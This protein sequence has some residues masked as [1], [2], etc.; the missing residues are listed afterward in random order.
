LLTYIIK[1]LLWV[2]PV[3][4]G[5]SIIV[6]IAMN[7]APGDPAQL[8]LGSQATEESLQKLR[9]EM[10]LDRNVF[11]QYGNFIS[12]LLVGDFGRSITFRQDVLPLVLM[13]LH[14]SII[15]GVASLLIAV[16]LGMGLGI[17]SAVKKNTWI[18]KLCMLFALT[19]ISMPIF[20][21]GLLLILFFSQTFGVLPSS[22]MYSSAGGGMFDLLKHII[23]PAFTLSLVPASVIARMTRSS[24]LE[25]IKQDYIR[26]ARAKGNNYW[27]VIVIH[28][29]K[30]A[31]VPVVTVLGLQV[32]YVIGG[33]VVVETIFAWPGVGQLLLEAVLTR[34]F[35]VVVGGAIILATIFVFCNILVDLL[36]GVIDPKIELE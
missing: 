5:V 29:F 30:N 7:L 20:W 12:N 4:L 15:L 11:V 34:D 33:A 31:L 32:G 23:L 28:A 21:L 26:T 25:V 24:M 19:G 22:G 6:F 1:R 2:I 36:Y 3:L 27:R 17:L 18:D 14:A 35:P 16:P 10:G 13:K 9:S 8:L